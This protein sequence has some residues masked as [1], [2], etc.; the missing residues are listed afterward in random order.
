MRF[1]RIELKR[2][3]GCGSNDYPCMRKCQWAF[4][5]AAPGNIHMGMKGLY[6]CYSGEETRGMIATPIALKSR[7]EKIMDAIL[8]LMG[9]N[10]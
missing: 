2:L 1:R 3:P 5:C 6:P 8:F 4:G 10:K 7:V 9:R